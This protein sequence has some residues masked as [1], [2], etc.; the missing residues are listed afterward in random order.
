MEI[1][2]SLPII[3]YLI[4]DQK[5]EGEYKYVPQKEPRNTTQRRLILSSSVQ[6]IIFHNTTFDTF[7]LHI[8]Y[9][10]IILRT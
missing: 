4:F 2:F 7:I 5:I 8:N 10:G 3:K 6:I 9:Y 1:I